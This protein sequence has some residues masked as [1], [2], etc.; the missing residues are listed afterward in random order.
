MTTAMLLDLIS[1]TANL[2]ALVINGSILYMVWK[3]DWRK[4][5]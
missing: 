5:R 1:I 3:D 2:I 4:D